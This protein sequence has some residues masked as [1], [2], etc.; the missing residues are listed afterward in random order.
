MGVK[1]QWHPLEHK[2][3][4]P[5]TSISCSADATLALCS[6]GREGMDRQ[7]LGQL[8]E[9]KTVPTIGPGHLAETLLHPAKRSQQP[10]C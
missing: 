2:G 1:R 6:L 7:R 5:P 10:P 8:S 3:A 9:H 4:V